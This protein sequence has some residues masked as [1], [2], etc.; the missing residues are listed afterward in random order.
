MG[1]KRRVFEAGHGRKLLVIVDETAE[2]EGAWAEVYGLLAGVMQ[3][4]ARVTEP[5]AA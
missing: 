1:K 3:D 4:A 5:R 2:V